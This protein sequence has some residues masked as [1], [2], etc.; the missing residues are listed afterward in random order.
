LKYDYD[1]NGL[2][3]RFE[4]DTNVVKYAFP[5]EYDQ[6]NQLKRLVTN[7]G[8]YS[9][10]KGWMLYLK[11]HLGNV[12]VVFD[13]K[14]K[15]LQRTDYYPFGLDIARDSLSNV[16]R[17]ATNRYLYNEK[18]VQ[19]RTGLIDYGARQYA[20]LEARWNGVDAYADFN[21]QES[22]SPFQFVGNS[23]I[24]NIDPD[25]NW[26]FGLFG[27][28]SEQ[29]Q[30][31]RAFANETGGSIVNYFSKNIGVRYDR[32]TVSGDG[33]G[34]ISE[35]GVAQTTQY[36]RKDGK[37]DFG[38][39]MANK[40]Y[41]DE[42]K[43]A[44]DAVPVGQQGK[45]SGAIDFDAGSQLTLGS[46]TLGGMSSIAARI[47]I[48]SPTNPVPSTLARVIPANLETSML[49]SPSAQDV[50]VTAAAD[51]SGLNAVQIAN[52]LTIPR[53]PSGFKIIKFKTP[54]MGVASPINRNNPGFVGFGR[55]AGGA[56]EFVI[57]NQAIPS[58]ST[59]KTVR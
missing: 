1:A 6:N 26:F 25:G 56:R 40:A 51:I 52:K 42:V 54:Q 21:D 2:K 53:S 58:N 35:I 16:A 15:V 49:G 12:R 38:S 13:S 4:S 8:Q 30:N 29:R 48:A 27:S 32:P 10:S 11:D 59:I 7:T 17:L 3:R 28:T 18:E 20:A 34:Q 55:T 22:L 31:A 33:N 41:D 47:G 36:F 44:W 57:P 23:P 5:F 19:P 24:N 14:G 50:F 9:P 46:L 37:L 39:I 45:G 43:E